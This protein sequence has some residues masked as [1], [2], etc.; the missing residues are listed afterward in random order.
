MGRRAL[1]LALW[2]AVTV[3]GTGVSFAIVSA[4]TANV[5]TADLAA[6][7]LDEIDASPQTVTS[8]TSS[9]PAPSST[10]GPPAPATTAAAPAGGGA[11]GVPSTTTTRPPPTV[12]SV[13]ATFSADGGV[14]TVVCDGSVI[15]LLSARP[16]ADYRLLVGTTGPERVD[17]AFVTERTGT[18][19]IVVCHDGVA[20]PTYVPVD[21]ERWDEDRRDGG[22]REGDW[23]DGSHGGDGDDGGQRPR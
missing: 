5:V 19:V 18:R 9:V 10:A 23:G 4:V 6:P 22:Y 20:R 7:R 15:R 3:V 16:E 8:A 13:P 2:T 14:V 12:E 1:A 21:A 17:V 11:A